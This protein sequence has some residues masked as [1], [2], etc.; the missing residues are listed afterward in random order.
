MAIRFGSAVRRREAVG[1]IKK[2]DTRDRI[3]MSQNH[4]PS[5]IGGIKYATCSIVDRRGG[6]GTPS[7]LLV[8]SKGRG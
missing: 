5:D 8:A 7:G 3:L 4:L 2:V 1:V 6:Y